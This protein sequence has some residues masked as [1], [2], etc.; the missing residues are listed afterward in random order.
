MLSVT[1]IGTEALYRACAS[2]NERPAV[3][4]V[5]SGFEYAPSDRP[6]SESWPIVPS[7]S[8]Y[9]AVKAAASAVAGA[10]VCTLGIA[11]LRP[12]HIYGAG[13]APG[14]LGPH[15]ISKAL[16]G[17]QIELTGGE[18][19]RDFL[20]VA[21]CA[22]CLWTGLS[23]ASGEPGLKVHNLGTGAGTTLRHYAKALASELAGRGLRADLDFGRLPY[24]ANEPMVSLPDTS[25]WQVATGWRPGVSLA[26]GIA[27]MVDRELAR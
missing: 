13:E 12:F 8:A 1:V 22:A 5:G 3:V 25:S 24:R 23:L 7:G 11:I 21:D 14:R 17:E 20:H 27:D 10:Y 16:S 9:G 15:I 4:H 26:A 2:L 18:Q 19:Q 6:V